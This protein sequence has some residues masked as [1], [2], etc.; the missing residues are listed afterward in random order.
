[1]EQITFG[2]DELKSIKKFIETIHS[3]G[4]LAIEELAEVG[5]VYNRLVAFVSAADA[6]IE[7]QKA[8]A[9]VQT[10]TSH[11]VSNIPTEA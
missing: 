2:L 7:Q 4:A 9:Q 10:E 11:I 1:M 6:A 3:R 5:I 8:Q